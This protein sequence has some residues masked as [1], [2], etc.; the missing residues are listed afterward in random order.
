[1]TTT[2]KVVEHTG[3]FAED[4]VVAKRLREQVLDPALA[5]GRR[6]TLNFAGV[7][8]ATQSFIHALLAAVIRGRGAA[9]LDLMT[10]THCN[11]ALKS[12]IRVVSEY[13]QE[14]DDEAIVAEGGATPPAATR[15]PRRSAR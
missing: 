2:V 7:D 1:M 4:K 12:L 11:A 5:G 9:A 15:G 13:S 10:F 14:T 3:S 8:I 6:V